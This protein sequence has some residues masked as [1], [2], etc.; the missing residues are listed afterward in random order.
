MDVL[1][2]RCCG[3]DLHRS[4]IMACVLIGA[5]G[6]KVSKE[7]RKFGTTTAQLAELGDWLMGLGIT[8][9]VMESTGV[10]WKPVHALLEDSAVVIVANARHVK[11][12]P[13]R[14]TDVGDAEWLADLARHGLVRASFVPPKPIRELREVVR[15]RRKLAEVQAR[16]RNRLIKVLETAGVKLSGV[17]SDVFGVS[18]RRLIRALIAGQ[19]APEQ[20]AALVTDG[21]LRKKLPDIQA[22]MCAE[23]KPHQVMMIEMQLERIERDEE[24]MVKLE[25]QVDT[26]LVPYHEEI[27]RMVVIP[28]IKQTTAAAVI[29]E[30][31]VDMSPWQTA[32]HLAAWAG[33]SPGNN[34]SAGKRKNTGHRKGNV[35]LQTL[36]VE[37]GW[38]ATRAKDSYLR[39]KFYKLKARRGHNRALMAI[40]RKLLI[41]IWHVL[42]GQPYHDLGADYL[43]KLDPQRAVR[44][45]TRR[46]KALGFDVA[47]TKAESEPL[48]ES[49]VA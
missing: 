4:S 47:L 49:E 42:V 19:T 48:Q 40:A 26:M 16:E 7:V 22:A 15:Y 38:A 25:G 14:K 5:A 21:R 24:H 27:E 30:I 45:L 2:E 29:A 9:V 39:A 3:L 6:R 31:G 8:H 32:D 28:G 46:L 18:G 44:T 11:Q 23:L 36:L 37:S 43:D 35:A 13:G 1:I 10:Y 12:V 17:L 33:V 20:V 34:E 41:A